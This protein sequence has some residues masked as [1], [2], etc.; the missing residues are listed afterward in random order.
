MGSV[1]SSESLEVEDGSL[2]ATIGELID[3][4]GGMVSTKEE[5]PLVAAGLLEARELSP[6]I[7]EALLSTVFDCPLAVTERLSES[8]EDWEPIV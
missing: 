1:E 2:L 3:P 5:K 7:P 6:P 8:D 4:D